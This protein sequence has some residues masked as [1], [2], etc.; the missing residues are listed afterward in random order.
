MHIDNNESE[1]ITIEAIFDRHPDI[2]LSSVKSCEAALETLKVFD[3][4]LILL[5]LIMPE[6]DG[7]TTLSEIRKIEGYETTPIVFLTGAKEVTMAN[8]YTKLGVIGVIH[9]PVDPEHFVFRLL[10]FW[11]AYHHNLKSA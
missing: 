3:P 6:H 5:D 11:E 1:L 4:Q 7:P 8:D 9:K 2:S 10:D